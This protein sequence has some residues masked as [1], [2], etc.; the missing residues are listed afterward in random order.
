MVPLAQYRPLSADLR[1]TCNACMWS[2]VYPLED[3][4]A[5]LCKRGLEGEKV[6]IK[7]VAQHTRIDCPRCGSRDWATTPA[8]PT[9]RGSTGVR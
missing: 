5:R 1:L 6:G 2:R 4:I 7:E 8:F 9:M 3:V